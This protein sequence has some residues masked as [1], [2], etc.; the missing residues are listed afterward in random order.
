MSEL[1]ISCGGGEGNSEF[2]ACITR[3]GRRET[4]TG[5]NQSQLATAADNNALCGVTQ[6]M[7]VWFSP[8]VQPLQI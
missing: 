4:D 6:K 3:D 2:F 8:R 1:K 5:A 7:R